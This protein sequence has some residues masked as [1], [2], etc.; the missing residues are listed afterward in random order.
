[1]PIAPVAPAPE[2]KRRKEKAKVKIPIPGTSWVRVTTNEGHTFYFEKESKRSEWSIPTEIAEAVAAFDEAERLEKEEK[3]KAERLEKLREQERVRAEIAEE[4]K[5]KAEEKKRK[6]TEESGNSRDA[7]TRKTETED[8]PEEQYA[9][10]GDDEEA[11]MKA[12][13]AEFAEADKKA[14]TD[15][16]DAE[17]AQKQAEEEAARK[18]FAAQREVKVSLEEGR[19][20]FKASTPS[21]MRS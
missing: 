18:V 15:A 2:K 13:A 4:R 7:K 17:A 10:E 8:D 14:A 3:A 20:L 1:M 19:A 6:A 21:D 5:R 12:V 11:W 16:E 9:P